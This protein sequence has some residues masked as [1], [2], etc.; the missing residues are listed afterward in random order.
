M[1][2][3]KIEYFLV[4]AK[5]LNYA[6]ASKQLYIS[7]QA[8]SKQIMLLENEIGEKL[9]ERTTRSVKLTEIGQICYEQFSLV[10]AQYDSTVK[11]I[12]EVVKSRQDTIRI[13][14]LSALPK[15]EVITPILQIISESCTKLNIEVLADGLEEVRDMLEEDKID[16][17]I[18]NIHEFENWQN[19]N[20]VKL[21]SMPAKIVISLYHPWVM[22]EEITDED[23]KNATILLYK[24]NR[25]LDPDSFYMRVNCKHKQYSNNFDSMLATLEIGKDFAVFPKVFDYMYKARFKYF[26]LPDKWKFQYFTAAIYKKDNYNPNIKNIL[27]NLQEDLKLHLN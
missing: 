23:L 12:L 22:K 6:E 25:H 24:K 1:D 10:K 9:L 11:N 8:L 19:C 2:F 3:H 27:E 13:G 14:V 18:T 20:V 15:N 26:D 21:A 16:L 5:T 17:C 4:L 7:P